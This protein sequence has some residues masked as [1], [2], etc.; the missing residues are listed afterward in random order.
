[1]S[2]F[3]VVFG[4][5]IYFLPAINATARSHH[6]QGAIFALNLLLGWTLIGWV[7]SFVWSC[8]AV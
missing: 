8:T 4:L 5:L 1:M 2:L 6:N 7:A 3:L